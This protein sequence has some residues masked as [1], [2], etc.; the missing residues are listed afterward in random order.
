MLYF[1]PSN[2]RHIT[3][4]SSFMSNLEGLMFKNTLSVVSVVHGFYMFVL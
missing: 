1:L 4:Y 2:V 3:N